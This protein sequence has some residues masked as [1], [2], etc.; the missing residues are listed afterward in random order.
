MALPFEV[1]SFALLGSMKTLYPLPHD[2]AHIE[3]V[4]SNALL[5]P[6]LKVFQGYRHYAA[7]STCTGT[8]THI[9]RAMKGCLL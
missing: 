6:V 1:S 9:I 2:E 8:H 5:K 7:A 3:T 4:K